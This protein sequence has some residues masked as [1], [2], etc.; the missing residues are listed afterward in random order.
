MKNT[1]NENSSS[2]TKGTDLNKTTFALFFS[3]PSWEQNFATS[4][5]P[6]CCMYKHWWESIIY[7]A[8]NGKRKINF[9]PLKPQNVR[10]EWIPG[11]KTNNRCCIKESKWSDTFWY[12]GYES[13]DLEIYLQR[14]EKILTENWGKVTKLV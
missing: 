7:Q 14:E 11:K 6:C 4:F 2:K 1:K 12:C 13:H 9:L 3:S 10:C 8:T 5:S